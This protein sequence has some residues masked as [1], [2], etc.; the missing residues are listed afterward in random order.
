MN[1]LLSEISTLC[2]RR[3]F[4]QDEIGERELSVSDRGNGNGTDCRPDPAVM[5]RAK[6]L[7][8]ELQRDYGDSVTVRADMCDEWV[9]LIISL[10][11]EEEQRRA[12]KARG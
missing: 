9:F 11:T 3:G 2:E 4:G 1:S 6:D 5:R 12:N 7:K 8:A 10:R